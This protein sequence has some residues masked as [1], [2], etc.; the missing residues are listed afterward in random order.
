MSLKTRLVIRLVS[1]FFLLPPILL[2][3]AGKV[4]WPEAWIY[5]V[6][7]YIYAI[8]AS[9]WILKNSPD[10]LQK[11]MAFEWPKKTWDLFFMIGFLPGALALF[12]IP[13]L[14]AVRYQWSDVPLTLKATGFIGL[15]LSMNLTFLAMKENPFS[16]K[17]VEIQKDKGHRVITTGPYR[18]VRHP[19]YVAVI[20]MFFSYSLALGSYYSLIT[21]LYMTILFIFRTSFEDRTL[22]EELAG[23]SDYVKTTRFKLLP[24]IW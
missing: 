16:S 17:I 20:F 21:S 13:G 10:L 19:M 23:Y 24:G 8:P 18:H 3:P 4:A 9:M 2:V 6:L 22:Q 15:A 11:R 1:G 7:S 12:I 5:C 14:D